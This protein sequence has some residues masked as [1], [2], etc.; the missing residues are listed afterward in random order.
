M[1][2]AAGAVNWREHNRAKSPRRLRLEVLQAVAQ[3]CDAVCFFQ[4]R[5]A[6]LRAGALPLRDASA[7]GH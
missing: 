2:Q 3:G 4:W 7:R 6:A 5:Q 1:E